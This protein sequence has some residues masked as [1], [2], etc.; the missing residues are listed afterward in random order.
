MTRANLEKFP[1]LDHLDGL[2]E[3]LQGSV[4]MAIAREG[5]AA[6]EPRNPKERRP[7]GNTRQGS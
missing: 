2:A 4:A 5:V 6:R 1:L 3:E 7:M